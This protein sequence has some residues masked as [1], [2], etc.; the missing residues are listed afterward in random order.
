MVYEQPGKNKLMCTKSVCPWNG[1]MWCG[2][3]W[4]SRSH[5]WWDVVSNLTTPEV[6]APAFLLQ[7]LI[8]CI[9][10][11]SQCHDDIWFKFSQIG[12]TFLYACNIYAL[13]TKVRPE[14][15][16]QCSDC[17]PGHSVLTF[18]ILPNHEGILFFHISTLNLFSCSVNV[19][20]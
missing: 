18:S 4:A 5:N 2:M 12:D 9:V 7:R 13:H 11:L 14:R 16:R 17:F 10:R 6:C 15:H 3:Q 19:I 8:Q 1:Y 20:T